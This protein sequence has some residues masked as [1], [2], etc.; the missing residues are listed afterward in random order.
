MGPDIRTQWIGSVS[1][2]HPLRRPGSGV[3]TSSARRGAPKLPANAVRT[4]FTLHV[5]TE[6]QSQGLRTE[7]SVAIPTTA[8]NQARS[9]SVDDAAALDQVRAPTPGM[10][11]GALMTVSQEECEQLARRRA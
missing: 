1:L 7:P 5:L 8:G 4:A 10:S 6:H 3:L 9:N 2:T 11:I